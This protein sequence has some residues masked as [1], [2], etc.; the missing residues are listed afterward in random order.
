MAEVVLAWEAAFFSGDPAAGS[1]RVA[2]RLGFILGREGGGLPPLLRVT[3]AFLGGAAGRG[4]QYLSWLHVAD[5]CQACLWVVQRRESSGT[6]NATAPAPVTNAA[7][8]RE[9]RRAA[10]RPWSPPVPAWAL[11]LVARRVLRVEPALVL[12]GCRAVPRRLL[13]EGFAFR[14]PALAPALRDLVGPGAVRA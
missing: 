5:F 7:F 6:Y 8:M 11:T 13:A 3:R 14:Y 2:L 12:N 1:R 4:R 9:L 10:G